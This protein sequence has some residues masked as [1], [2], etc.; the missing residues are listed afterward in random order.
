MS[1]TILV[2]INIFSVLMIADHLLPVPGRSPSVG[3]YMVARRRVLPG[4]QVFRDTPAVIGPDNS[5][6]P[7]CTVCWR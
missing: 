6:V 5:S 2:G 7:L 4:E 1:S 3:R